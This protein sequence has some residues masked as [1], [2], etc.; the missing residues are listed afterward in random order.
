MITVK[1]V[2]VLPALKPNITRYLNKDKP[3]DVT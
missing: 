1:A 3:T 2:K